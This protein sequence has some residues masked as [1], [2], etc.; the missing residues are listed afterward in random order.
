MTAL[1]ILNWRDGDGPTSAAEINIADREDLWPGFLKSPGVFFDDRTRAAFPR[2]E[3]GDYVALLGGCPVIE[4][5]GGI[6]FSRL[7]D[8]CERFLDKPGG[9]FTMA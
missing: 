9:G 2:A 4:V 6:D 1:L 8:A 3:P 5:I 7:A